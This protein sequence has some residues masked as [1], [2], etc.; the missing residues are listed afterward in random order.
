MVFLSLVVF[1]IRFG[2]GL[3]TSTDPSRTVLVTASVIIVINE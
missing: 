2:S 3:G 1:L